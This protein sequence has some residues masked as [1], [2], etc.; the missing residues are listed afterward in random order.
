MIGWLF[1]YLKYRSLAR[2]IAR[3]DVA[4]LAKRQARKIGYRQV[5]RL[6]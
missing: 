3:G 4:G 2:L 5:R 1:R 6:R